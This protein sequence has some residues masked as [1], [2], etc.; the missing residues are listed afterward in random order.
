MT[1]YSRSEHETPARRRASRKPSGAFEKGLEAAAWI[2]TGSVAKPTDGVWQPRRHGRR[3]GKAPSQLV[4][5]T[6][7]TEDIRWSQVS[8]REEG[9]V[10]C[11][12][13]GF[14]KCY[15][16]LRVFE[17]GN[18][19]PADG[20]LQTIGSV[21]CELNHAERELPAK[22]MEGQ[23]GLALGVTGEGRRDTEMLRPHTVGCYGSPARGEA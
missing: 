10:E 8:V 21:Y 2:R 16:Q 7:S 6:T 18:V 15:F 4:D 9:R 20:S 17:E 14:M 19:L 23:C 1:I 5:R 22:A 11:V 3:R 13:C 12:Y